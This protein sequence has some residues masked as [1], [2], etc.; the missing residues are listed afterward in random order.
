MTDPMSVHAASQAPV[1]DAKAARV[2]AAHDKTPE[3]PVA[4]EGA[5]HPVNAE[6]AGNPDIVPARDPAAALDTARSPPT[7]RV[8]LSA[9]LEAL[10]SN[11]TL[12]PFTIKF[13]AQKQATDMQVY[14]CAACLLHAWQ[15]ASNNR[16]GFA[17]EHTPVL[18]CRLIRQVA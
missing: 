18:L 3:P 10:R 16:A 4:D 14:D 7:P 13:S 11:V 17:A 2:P 8:I 15:E 5:P 9:P 6:S 12:A 1:L